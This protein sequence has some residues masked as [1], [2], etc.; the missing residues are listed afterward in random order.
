LR[1]IHPVF[2]VVVV[3]GTEEAAGAVGAEVG[4]DET[5]GASGC[6]FVVGVVVMGG[7]E[8]VRGFP[9]KLGVAGVDGRLS[10]V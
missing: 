5:E 4:M 6:D 10:G 2:L 7:G 9:N 3:E 8:G 1:F